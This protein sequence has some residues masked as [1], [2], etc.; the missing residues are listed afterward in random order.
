VAAL[1]ARRR[2][3]N[4]AGREL[5][6][7]TE[8]TAVRTGIGAKAFLPQKIDRHETADEKKRDGHCYRGK[9]LPKIGSHQMIGEFGNKR[10]VR[11]REESI[12]RGPNKHV[13]RA[14]ER[15]IHQQSRPE[16]LWM[17]PHL[18]QQPAA[19]ILQSE[20]VTAPAANV[21]PENQR[22]QDRQTKK[23]EA[24]IDEPLLQRVHGFRRLDGRNRLAH[25]AP[26]NDVR[27]HEQ[28]ENN[29]RRGAPPAGL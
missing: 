24:C 10:F 3:P 18:F 28:I 23:D 15:H 7:E 17:K 11:R 26:L 27:D 19:E 5:V 12:N 29:Q 14:N 6:S 22:R 4:F 16:R 20:N 1:I 21:S 9:R 2:D 8:E 13:Q 25:D